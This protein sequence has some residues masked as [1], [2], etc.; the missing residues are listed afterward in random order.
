VTQAFIERIDSWV[1]S[2][3]FTQYPEHDSIQEEVLRYAYRIQSESD[4][5][6][7]SGIACRAKQRLYESDFDFLEG[8]LSALSQLKEFFSEAIEMVAMEMNQSYWPEDALVKVDIVESWVHVTSSGGY[9]DIHSHPNCS[10]C[11]IYYVDIGDSS[12]SKTGLNRF[13]DPRVNASHYL[14]AG[15]M[16]IHEEGVMDVEPQAGKLVIFP[17]Y[18]KHSAL[19]Y[20]GE[21]DRV[22]IAF[23][24]QVH[25]LPSFI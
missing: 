25:L 12:E 3:F 5:L 13:Y 18:M 19:T 2:I 10:W 20:I 1:S 22:V 14:D 4:E 24:A 6:V 16:Y 15:C 21:A 7:Q 11:G 17:S 23:N 8:D 9:H